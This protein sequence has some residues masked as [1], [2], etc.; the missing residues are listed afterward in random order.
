M[1][2]GDTDETCDADFI[3]ASMPKM[4]D[5]SILLFASH[6]YP[7]GLVGGPKASDIRDVDFTG[8]V[9]FNIAC[10]TGVTGAW[11]EDDW[12]TMRVR[13]REVEASDSFC[14]QMIDS[15]V[16]GYVAYVSP[17]PGGPQMMGDALLT[18]ASG[19]SLGE[20]QRKE[21]EQCCAGSSSDW[22]RQGYRPGASGWS[23]DSCGT[24]SG[25]RRPKDVCWRYP[26]R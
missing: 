24:N 1:S 14:L 11:F 9:A 4:Q 17:R 8:K 22:S 5:G 12:K 23:T 6:G 16:A 26:D 20:L 25:Q 2:H 21:R 18:G 13:R 19:L 7:N 3:R 10:Y 15:G